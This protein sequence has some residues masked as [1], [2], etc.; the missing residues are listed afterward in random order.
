MAEQRGAKVLWS[1]A[2]NQLVMREFFDEQR[3]GL[4]PTAVVLEAVPNETSLSS[5]VIEFV[6]CKAFPALACPSSHV[7][8][9][10]A[11][12]SSHVIPAQDCAE[13]GIYGC[14]KFMSTL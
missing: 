9:S 10:L 7:I 5:H 3:D 14:V 11:S 2:H 1:E 13:A 8:P 4:F 6:E 12:N